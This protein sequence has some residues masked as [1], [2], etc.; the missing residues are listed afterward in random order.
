HLYA[1][2][3]GLSTNR[4]FVFDSY[5]KEA[6]ENAGIRHVFYLPVGCGASWY[7]CLSLTKEAYERYSCDAAFIGKTYAEDEYHLYDGW[8]NLSEFE[9]GYL[10]G[11]VSAQKSIYGYDLLTESLINEIFDAMKRVFPYQKREGNA[12]S[13]KRILSD[14]LLAR[15]VTANERCEVLTSLAKDFSLRVYTSEKTVKI[16]GAE[17]MGWIDYYNDAPLAIRS[18]KVNLNITLKSIRRGIPLRVMDILGCGGFLVSNYQEDMLEYFTP[19]EDFVLYESTGEIPD[20]VSYYL[21]HESERE[22]IAQA[23]YRKAKN[24]L[25]WEL[26]TDKILCLIE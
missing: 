15:R 2:E 19:G 14:Y 16:P 4:I 8:K 25:S 10:D 26:Q 5:E 17:M 6:L 24:Q 12:L 9:S 22:K 13:E 11:L 18:A 20:I 21:G 7:D 3:A 1:P 23:G